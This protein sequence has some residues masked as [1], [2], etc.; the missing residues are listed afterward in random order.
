MIGGT[1]GHALMSG[2]L[3]GSRSGLDFWCIQYEL[4]GLPEGFFFLPYCR[5][6]LFFVILI[7]GG[8]GDIGVALY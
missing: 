1:V 8:G 4:V 6:G 5:L 3:L 7:V 2:M